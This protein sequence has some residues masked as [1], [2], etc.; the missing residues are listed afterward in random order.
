MGDIQS[1]IADNKSQI[2][3]ACRVI[4]M[5]KRRH[6]ASEIAET[7]PPAEITTHESFSEP[8]VPPRAI[9]DAKRVSVQAS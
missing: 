9:I 7:S 8:K 1:G 2:L 3:S 4:G 6:D 5:T